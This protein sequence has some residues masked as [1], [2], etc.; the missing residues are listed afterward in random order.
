M[1]ENQ[2][3]KKRHTCIEFGENVARPELIPNKH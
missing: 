3:D 2:A 1:M